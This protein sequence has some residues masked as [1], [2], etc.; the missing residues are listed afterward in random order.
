MFLIRDPWTGDHETMSSEEFFRWTQVAGV[1][2]RALPGDADSRGA[3]PDGIATGKYAIEHEIARGGIGVVMR[4][5]D[6]D[7]GRC[8]AIKFLQDQFADSESALQR[9]VEEAQIGGQ[10]QH[11]G[12]VPVYEL[13]T[14]DGRPFFAMKLIQGETL[15]EQLNARENPQH[16]VARFLGMFET[17][18]QTMAYAHARGVIHRDLKPGNVMVG[19]FGEVQ[20]VDW[21]VAK[22]LAQENPECRTVDPRQPSVRTNRADSTASGSKSMDGAVIG[23][24][25][26]M[27]PEQARGEV[28]ELD[29]RADVFGLGAILCHIL[30]GTPPFTGG[31]VDPILDA[32]LANT[33]GALQRLDDSGA[34]PEI[35]GLS[36][37]CLRADPDDRP[38]SAREVADR[39]ADYRRTV[40]ERARVAMM[41]AAA[42]R[43][44]ARSTVLLSLAAL[45]ISLISVGSWLYLQNEHR[46]HR[47]SAVARIDGSRTE[48]RAALATAR[49]AGWRRLELWEAAESAAERAADDARSEGIDARYLAAATAHS[50]EVRKE[51]ADIRAEAARRAKDTA[52]RGR[53]ERVRISSDE[54][55]NLAIWEQKDAHRQR[56][57]FAAAFSDYADNPD[58]VSMSV[59]DAAVALTGAIQLELA[60]GLDL[61]AMACQFQDGPEAR[62]NVARLL[63]IAGRLD[64]E[65]AWRSELRGI[66]RNARQNRNRLEQL[67]AAVDIHGLAA[68]S[69]TLL[70]EGLVVAEL[71]QA[72]LALYLAGSNYHPGDFGMCF[73]A[74]VLAAVASDFSVAATYFARARGLRPEMIAPQHMLGIALQFSGDPAGAAE[75][76]ANLVRSHPDDDHLRYHLADALT[77]AGRHADADREFESILRRKPNHVRALFG[78][79]HVGRR[80][81]QFDLAIEFAQEALRVQP[82]SLVAVEAMSRALWA[83]QRWPEA[84]EHA[85]RL[86]RLPG[87]TASHS[88]LTGNILRGAGRLARS[89]EVLRSV[90]ELESDNEQGHLALGKALLRANRLGDARHHYERALALG[91]GAAARC[92]VAQVYGARNEPG[93]EFAELHRALQSDPLHARANDLLLQRLFAGNR[94]DEA[95]SQA[96]AVVDAPQADAAVL[97]SIGVTLKR[98]GHYRLAERAHR[99]V[100]EQAPRAQSYYNLSTALSSQEKLAEA[101]AMLR[102]ALEF[103]PR[104]EQAWNNLAAGLRS[105]FRFVDSLAALDRG[106]EHSPGS[107]LLHRLRCYFRAFVG[108]IEGARQDLARIAELLDRVPAPQ[109]RVNL[110]ELRAAIDQHDEKT[111]PLREALE[112]SEAR[113]FGAAMLA[114]GLS[115]HVRCVELFEAAML[116]DSGGSWR[117]PY[118]YFAARAALRAVAESAVLTN[119]NR[120]ALRGKALA[121][122]EADLSRFVAAGQV[123]ELRKWLTTGDFDIVRGESLAKLGEDVRTD[124]SGFWQRFDATVR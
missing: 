107:L 4:G 3:R 50:A 36:R 11:P 33:D 16:D 120:A 61:W 84:C 103:N 66:L 30:T 87:A 34:D 102:K 114:F 32:S 27:A 12:I 94:V 75:V 124:W 6:G 98:N 64:G 73:R 110:D 83:A 58:L 42:A 78:R 89:I 117:R 123:D 116:D 29:E 52:M 53:L 101:T 79:S 112:A 55:F 106:L 97:S 2:L 26:Y 24:P 77:D 35:I 40:E 113:G 96:T 48:S 8:V 76:F 122:L 22:V 49:A 56:S 63:A 13:G 86:A 100:L 99:R 21:G 47:D 118:R 93:R 80:R 109:L 10:L 71:H 28:D 14:R 108:D 7:L 15:L 19:Q 23:T 59:D 91:A 115:K 81:G 119:S 82:N 57:E 60:A 92:G 20:I 74:A 65:D 5:Q 121:W 37:D 54:T 9:F 68:H 105:N 104:H 51:H 39:V 18:C 95:L 41:R 72:A 31:R 1:R 45:L 17:V 111:R 85:E 43:V 70:A 38:A 62:R 88:V 46:R 69:I 67:A 25:G 44:R 90:V